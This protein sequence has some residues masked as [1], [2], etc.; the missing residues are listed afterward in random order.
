M[1][2]EQLSRA[3]ERKEVVVGRP[4][5]EGDTEWFHLLAMHQNRA[6]SAAAGTSAVKDVLQPACMDIVIW[7]H[8]RECTVG[9]G[10]D[11]VPEAQGVSFSVLQPGAA[12]ATELT[13]VESKPKSVA[14]LQICGEAWK[15]ESLPLTTVRPYLAAEVV[16]AEY[17]DE[18]NL[19]NEEELRE[20][21]TYRQPRPRTTTMPMWPFV[22][23]PAALFA[24]SL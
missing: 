9:G 7:G 18:R 8:E 23:R 4:E 3:L 24:R 11:G 20:L 19:H 1:R 14:V 13:D 12:V 16:L 10:M 22:S 6:K 2:D 5:K 17:E 15:L 21:Y